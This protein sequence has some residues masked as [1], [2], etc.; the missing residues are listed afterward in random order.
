MKIW[1]KFYLTIIRFR[2]C[3]A[4]IT[5][6]QY[7]IEMTWIKKT[8][9]TKITLDFHSLVTFFIL[10]LTKSSS[11]KSSTLNDRFW[12]S[13]KNMKKISIG[14]N[15][16]LQYLTY[17]YSWSNK[18]VWK[19][20]SYEILHTFISHWRGEKRER[21]FLLASLNDSLISAAQYIFEI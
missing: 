17:D 12:F 7:T 9:E 10:N 15:C 1:I 14:T 8:S 6:Q 18:C 13:N 20:S 5:F 3:I 19:F 11:K 4:Y 16:L 21:K 2:I